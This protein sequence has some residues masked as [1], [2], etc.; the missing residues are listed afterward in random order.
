[1]FEGWTYTDDGRLVS[2]QGNT[3]SNNKCK[4]GYAKVEI[5]GKQYLQHRVVFFLHNG[6]LPRVVDHKDRD[7]LNNRPSNL[8]DSTYQKNAQNTGAHSDSVSGIKGVSP[9]RKN[10]ILN[11]SWVG[12]I[13]IGAKVYQKQFKKKSQAIA[14]VTTIYKHFNIESK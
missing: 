12:K 7:R 3:I 5:Q 1:M 11:G 4:N 13:R 8:R 10:G 2:P 14:F 6:Y 9:V